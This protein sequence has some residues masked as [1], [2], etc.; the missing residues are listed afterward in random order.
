MVDVAKQV[1]Y[2][3]GGAEEALAASHDLL[4]S[5]RFRQCLF[6]AYLAL[7][8]MLKAL[9][10]RET[11][12]LAP[13]MTNLLKLARK[14]QLLLTPEQTTSLAEINEFSREGLYPKVNA[15]PLAAPATERRVKAAD[16]LCQWL[17]QRL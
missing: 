16:E 7:E 11:N 5:T 6:L 13:R 8:K 9:V 1:A 15:A 10:C 3:R 14:A 12:D 17:N 2:W 4:D